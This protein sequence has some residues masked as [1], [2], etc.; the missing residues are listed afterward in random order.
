MSKE[1]EYDKIDFLNMSKEIEYD[2]IHFLNRDHGV[3]LGGIV[4]FL[5]KNQ[6]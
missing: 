6:T 3:I 4:I 5:K 2:N 1:I